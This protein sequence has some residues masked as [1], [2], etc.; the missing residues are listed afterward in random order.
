MLV[1]LVCAPLE[2][3]VQLLHRSGDGVTFRSVQGRGHS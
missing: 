2:D 1:D 3:I